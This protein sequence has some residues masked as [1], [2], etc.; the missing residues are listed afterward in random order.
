M[1][2][3]KRLLIFVSIAGISVFLLS[4]IIF[5]ISQA[6]IEKRLENDNAIHDY[7]II[8]IL[9]EN[10]LT[11]IENTASDWAIWDD[12][13]YFIQDQNEEYKNVNLYTN[14]L[15]L[16]DMNGIIFIN[17]SNEIIYDDYNYYGEKKL[18]S[19]QEKSQLTDYLSKIDSDSATGLLKIDDKILFFSRQKIFNSDSSLE[20]NGFIIFLRV[21]DN[22]TLENINTIL[23]SNVLLRTNSEVSD[24]VGLV[25]E[26]NQNTYIKKTGKDVLIK[27]RIFDYYE[28]EIGEYIIPYSNK[29][30]L[31]IRKAFNLFILVELVGVILVCLVYYFGFKKI[32]ISKI[33][34]MDNE[35][36]T[37]LDKKDLSKNLTLTADEEIKNLEHSFNKLIHWINDNTL[38]VERKNEELTQLNAEL[39]K[40]DQMKDNLISAVSHELRTPLTSIQSYTQLLQKDILGK[41][42]KKQKESLDIILKS[43]KNL[44]SMIS[45]IL[46]SSKYESGKMQVHF[47]SFNLYSLLDEICIEYKPW[48]RSIGASISLNFSKS[49]FI[50]ADREKIKQIFLNLFTNSIKYKSEKRK[51]KIIV[52]VNIKNENVIISVRDNGIGIEKENLK[53]LFNKFY[54]VDQGMTRK[55]EGAGLGLAIIKYIVTIHEGTVEVHSKFGEYTEFIIKIS[56]KLKETVKGVQIIEKK[57]SDDLITV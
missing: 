38:A 7:E 20:S 47:E 48:L 14:P 30:I 26:I 25:K 41:T 52:K 5:I 11:F 23:N 16:L 43:V 40:F 39:K 31:D 32:V 51:L 22:R 10:K 53:N 12:T 34:Y 28:K 8:S 36:S 13:Y 42:N 46:D 45:K 1:K 6:Q 29:E 2:L 35:I 55:V 19:E 24:P 18:F 17:S 4:F 37:M 9:M 3:E 57:A 15:D 33:T 27:I 44:T 49:L 56:N 21:L 54:Q 50:I